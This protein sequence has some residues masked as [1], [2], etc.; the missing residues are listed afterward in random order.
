MTR[1]FSIASDLDDEDM[2]RG[3][4]MCRELP[5][6]LSTVSGAAISQTF[7]TALHQAG[8]LSSSS[9]S[10]KW[11]SVRIEDSSYATRKIGKSIVVVFRS[12]AVSLFG[13][14]FTRGTPVLC[15]PLAPSSP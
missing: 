10:E 2:V 9:R 11:C 8:L 13:S 14:V 3:V 12:L 4:K 5:V 7:R 6:K 1:V 15:S